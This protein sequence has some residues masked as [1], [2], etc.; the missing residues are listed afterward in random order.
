M[1]LVQALG[2]IPRTR[3]SLLSFD[4]AQRYGVF[5]DSLQHRSK[6][7]AQRAVFEAVESLSGEL[8]APRSVANFTGGTILCRE[9]R[10]VPGWALSV[11][12]EFYSGDAPW[13]D[14]ALIMHR[15]FPDEQSRKLIDRHVK[16]ALWGEDEDA[17]PRSFW[18]FT[19][20]VAITAQ[21]EAL[22]NWVVELERAAEPGSEP[23]SELEASTDRPNLENLYLD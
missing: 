10:C 15:R 14:V 1:K 4:F 8:G 6:G 13:C 11:S 19:A 21:P 9:W 17:W 23:A 16:I 2:T 5:V 12:A 7:L 18:P 3:H 22:P 20:P